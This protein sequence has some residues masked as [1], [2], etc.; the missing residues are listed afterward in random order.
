[1]K[2]GLSSVC[3]FYAKNYKCFFYRDIFIVFQ[4]TVEH[5]SSS[6]QTLRSKLLNS[7]SQYESRTFSEDE[8]TSIVKSE[9]F[10]D[11]LKT[12]EK[13]FVLIYII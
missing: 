11:F 5:E 13:G 2:L 9:S 10:S 3:N 8:C 12:A 4:A 1:M 7:W 6:A